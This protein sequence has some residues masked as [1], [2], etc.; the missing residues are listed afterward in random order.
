MVDIKP[1]SWRWMKR[2]RFYPESCCTNY[3]W[4]LEGAIRSYQTTHRYM[5]SFLEL[6]SPANSSSS[7]A[8]YDL[9]LAHSHG[10]DCQYCMLPVFLWKFA[11]A[12]YHPNFICRGHRKDPVSKPD[13]YI[14]FSW[15]SSGVDHVNH[16]PYLPVPNSNHIAD[17]SD[18]PFC[19]G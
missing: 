10:P 18:T 5:T 1:L 15:I 11:E 8:G 9:A 13:P 4:V 14:I 3:G 12:F 17:V 2:D 6:S 7:N 19:P 16:S